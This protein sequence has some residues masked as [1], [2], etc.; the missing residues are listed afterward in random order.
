MAKEQLRSLENGGAE[1]ENAQFERDAASRRQCSEKPGYGGKGGKAPSSRGSLFKKKP[2]DRPLPRSDIISSPAT[3]SSAALASF[4]TRIMD[5]ASNFV[6]SSA[7]YLFE[8]FFKRRKTLWI[9]NGTKSTAERGFRSG[10]R[11]EAEMPFATQEVCKH[12]EVSEVESVKEKCTDR[13]DKED[14]GFVELE[15]FLKSRTLSREEVKRLTEVLQACTRRGEE[16]YH[17]TIQEVRVSGRHGIVKQSKGES[18]PVQLAK[19]YMGKRITDQW[20]STPQGVGPDI[21]YSRSRMQGARMI[22]TPNREDMSEGRLTPA[23]SVQVLKRRLLTEDEDNVNKLGPS[24][25]VRQKMTIMASASPYIR[26]VN[27]RTGRPQTP[28]LP[29]PQAIEKAEKSP[30]QILAVTVPSKG[31]SVEESVSAPCSDHAEDLPE[32]SSARDV[33]FPSIEEPSASMDTSSRLSE[34]VTALPNITMEK[35]VSGSLTTST[36]EL[37]VFPPEKSKGFRISAFFEDSSSD[38]EVNVSAKASGLV[39]VGLTKTSESNELLI[40]TTLKQSSSLSTKDILSTSPAESW[41]KL[42]SPTPALDIKLETLEHS[43]VK[44]DSVPTAPLVAPLPAALA[45][46][47]SRVSFEPSPVLFHVPSSQEKP[48]RSEKAAAME[49]TDR[50]ADIEKHDNLRFLANISK[51]ASVSASQFSVCPMPAQPPSEQSALAQPFSFSKVA[52]RTTDEIHLTPSIEKVTDAGQQ[53]SEGI[54]IVQSDYSVSQVDMGSREMV[55]PKVASPAT[56]SKI[57]GVPLFMAPSS[58]AEVGLSVSTT[59]ISSIPVL[60]SVTSETKITGTQQNIVTQ[61][62]TPLENASIRTS[63][64]ESPSAADKHG[65]LDTMV[66]DSMVEEAENIP[67]SS[68]APSLFFGS[69]SNTMQSS[70]TTFNAPSAPSPF[71]FTM[72]SST[73][74][75]AS[76]TAQSLFGSQTSSNNGQSFA[77]GASGPSPVS[78]FSANLQSTFSFGSSSSTSMPSSTVS[79]PLTLPSSSPAPSPFVFGSQVSA[80]T[81]GFGGQMASSASMFTSV[82]QSSAPAF[83]FQASPSPPFQFGGAS[84][85]T[86]LSS[87]SFGSQAFSFGGQTTS[88]TVNPFSQ[89]GGPNAG[90]PSSTMANPFA[91][92]AGATG[93]LFQFGATAAGASQPVFSTGTNAASSFSFGA[94]PAPPA[95][96]FAFGSQPTSMPTGQPFGFGSQP[97]APAQSSFPLPGSAGQAPAGASGMEFTGGFSLGAAGGEKSGRKFYKAKRIGSVKRK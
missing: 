16:S 58:V 76:S 1:A 22:S 64:S 34:P 50:T 11:S 55:T 80:S 19:E 36:S 72:Q 79:A 71:S 25:R 20:Q 43:V 57:P 67:A 78:S 92:T 3:V 94:Q 82:A 56:A 54:Q 44:S 75:T 81:S 21:L 30:E 12:A 37:L 90:Q 9:G 66:T 26:Q 88:A 10:Q 87:S 61:L 84:A 35:S 65:D 17:D 68:A 42:T 23:T 73:P 24:R 95:S 86:S 62:G 39:G 46:E 8:S 38:E 14:T 31:K 59:P 70:S 69:A 89:A 77:F 2:Y 48:D 13:V 53:Q 91:Q 41:K 18:N 4:P 33:V 93:G 32:S 49:S 74:S 7:S 45:P 6:T 83:S 40:E 27:A 5:S 51:S 60:Q 15:Q 29:I 96:P 97:A 28:N 52:S 85:G 63:I 47:K